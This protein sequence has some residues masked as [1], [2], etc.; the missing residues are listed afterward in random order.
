MNAGHEQDG[1]IGHVSSQIV[2]GRP[3]VAL[4]VRRRRVLVSVGQLP[5][6][7]VVIGNGGLCRRVC[8]D[9]EFPA[10]A[11]PSAGRFGACFDEAFDYL[12]GHWVGL[13]VSYGSLGVNGVEESDLVSQ[14]LLQLYSVFASP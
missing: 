10:L 5:R 12:A 3:D 9:E 8:D 4:D 14:G 7:E 13:Q 2:C 11:I 6:L 1:H